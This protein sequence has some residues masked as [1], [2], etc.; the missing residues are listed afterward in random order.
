MCTL[1]KWLSVLPAT[2]H[3]GSTATPRGAHCPLWR[4]T[5]LHPRPLASICVARIF[6]KVWL[7]AAFFFFFRIN[8]YPLGLTSTFKSLKR[9]GTLL[10]PKKSINCF[11]AEETWCPL[12]LLLNSR[13]WKSLAEGF[14]GGS[15]VKN[16]PAST[17]DM[18]SI[19]GLGGSHMLQGNQAPVPQLLSP[20][21]RAQEPQLLSP[22]A[23]DQEP[24]LLSPCA[25][26][27]EPQLLSPCAGDQEPQ[28]LS[29]CARA[30]EPQLLSPCAEDQ[31]PQLLSPCA[32]DQEPQ[33]LSPCA[34]TPEAHTPWSLCSAPREATTVRSPNTATR[35]WPMLASTRESSEQAATKSQGSQK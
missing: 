1:A 19:P 33:L 25:G 9:K 16:L 28:L 15:V 23:G 31:E 26:D 8:I 34:A 30:Q 3:E 12:H 11:E 21:A 20:C 27:Q 22:C 10:P 35:E 18:G 17:G 29:P 32:G 5:L 2:T 24:Q 4:G 6:F 13:L 7:R 14:L